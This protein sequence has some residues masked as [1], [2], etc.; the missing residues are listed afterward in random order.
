[1]IVF[2][3]I[4]KKL[5]PNI[6]NNQKMMDSNT[7]YTKTGRGLRAVVRKL[8]KN[9]GYVLSILDKGLNGE[10]I[11][12][13]LPKISNKELE[14]AISWLLEGGF[15][16]SVV[17]DPFSNTM[18]EDSNKSSIEVDEID[19]G[20]GMKMNF[21]NIWI[22]KINIKNLNLKLQTNFEELDKKNNELVLEVN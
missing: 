9:A 14:I 1:M 8:P 11:Q 2:I 5:E 17:V 3:Y 22:P 21:S 19:V 16:K 4:L 10:Q 15:I 13:A 18:W 20:Y 12:E 6:V 7:T